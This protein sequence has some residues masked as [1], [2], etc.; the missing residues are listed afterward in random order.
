MPVPGRLDEITPDWLTGALRES[1]Q[2]PRGSVGAVTVSA[3]GADRGFTGVVAR[4]RPSYQDLD[5]GRPVPP[6][7]LV[8]KLPTA[9]P[10]TRS[11]YRSRNQ[12]DAAAADRYYRRCAREVAC[13]RELGPVL[14]DGAPRLYHA[15]LDERDRRVVLLLEDYG[16][17][18]G[19]PGDA[20]AGG[21]TAQAAAIL[22]AVVPVHA[23]GWGRAPAQWVPSLAVDPPAGQRWY[24]ERA[25]RFLARHR[26]RVPAPVAGLVERLRGGYAEVLAELAR[27]PATV[28]HGD[29]HLDNVIFDPPGRPVAVLDWQGIGYGPAVVDLADVLFGSLPADHR[30]PAEP[31]LL[32]RY[33]AALASGEV[34][35]YSP[36]AL[37]RDLRLALQRMLALRVA[38]LATVD[39]DTL[40]VGRERAL[41]E[42][43]FG[44]GRLVAALRDHQLVP[45]G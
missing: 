1:G 22:D 45:A 42:A 37:R 23:A 33:A 36:A 24:A 14:G 31:A 18:G 19:R 2:L 5:P 28:V 43:A 16:A 20:L 10:Y 9:E 32:A 15:E 26:H 44:D 38:W 17:A 35:G 8:A 4:V 39:P 13:Y 6:E 27:A 3:I 7:S 12:A 21:T 25:E 40:A 41:V 29:L 30:R 11:A 34:T